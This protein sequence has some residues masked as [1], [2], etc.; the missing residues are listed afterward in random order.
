MG[1]SGPFRGAEAA[2]ASFRPWSAVA[3]PGGGSDPPDSCPGRARQVDP[4]CAGLPFARGRHGKVAKRIR[5]FLGEARGGIG[6]IGEASH[7]RWR[8]CVPHKMI[9][10]FPCAP[11]R[12]RPRGADRVLRC[13]RIGRAPFRSEP[14]DCAMS[15]DGGD[16]RRDQGAA[17]VA[18]RR[19]CVDG[20]SID[21]PSTGR[22]GVRESPETVESDRSRCN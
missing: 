10:P 7:P 20:R 8:P 5:K 14:A 6:G 4:E 19:V 2:A 16:V 22:A 12:G 21:R 3:L 1:G 13:S 9:V 18:R 17:V 15:P 11:V